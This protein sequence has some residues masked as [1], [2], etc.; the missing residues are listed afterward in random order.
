MFLSLKPLKQWLRLVSRLKTNTH[1]EVLPM[2]DDS[3]SQGSY[4]PQLL[5]RGTVLAAAGCAFVAGCS[6]A[7]GGET[8]YD[9]SPQFRDGVFQNMPN[10]EVLPSASAWRIW[11]RFIV[12][13]KVDTVP[14][15]PI[16]VHELDRHGARCARRQGQ[17]CRAAGPFVAPAQAA[18]QVLADRPGVQRARLAGAMGRARSAFTSRR[19]RS[20]DLPPIEG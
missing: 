10:P 16:P 1:P 5:R 6:A 19:S 13:S 8:R 7:G 9:N 15:D 11:S 2:A 17:P 14:V 4:L 12:G 20:S 3:A 18:G